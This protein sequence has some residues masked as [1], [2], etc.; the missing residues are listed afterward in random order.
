[1]L[2]DNS[3]H[4]KKKILI[5]FALKYSIGKN[6]LNI[7]EQKIVK[8]CVETIHTYFRKI[9]SMAKILKNFLHKTD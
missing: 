6:F 2:F 1:M 5:Y 3:N 8:K 9:I 7:F 4:L